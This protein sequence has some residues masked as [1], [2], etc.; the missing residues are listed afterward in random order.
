MNT[1]A[2][3]TEYWREY[4]RPKK[5]INALERL[6]KKNELKY[7]ETVIKERVL[8]NPKTHKINNILGIDTHTFMT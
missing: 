1:K 8:G 6:Q 2:F 7:A 5:K 4:F 3:L